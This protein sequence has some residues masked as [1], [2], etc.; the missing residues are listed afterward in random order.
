MLPRPTLQESSHILYLCL[1]LLTGPATQPA[2][3]MI[4]KTRMFLQRP[5]Q[6]ELSVTQNLQLGLLESGLWKYLSMMQ[7][8]TKSKRSLI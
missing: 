2:F 6:L 1:L 7:L 8:S 5:R 3:V 4:Q